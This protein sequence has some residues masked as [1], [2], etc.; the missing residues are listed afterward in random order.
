MGAAELPSSLERDTSKGLLL[1]VLRTI[2]KRGTRN[3]EVVAR[4]NMIAL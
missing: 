4:S 1:I 3:G 2:E